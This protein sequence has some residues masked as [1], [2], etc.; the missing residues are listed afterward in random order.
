MFALYLAVD[1]IEPET[2]TRFAGGQGAI[3]KWAAV[4]ARL[5]LAPL[6]HRLP[7]LRSGLWSGIK[8]RSTLPA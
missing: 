3:V 6:Y 7:W 5:L 2:Q 4:A 1:K 8:F